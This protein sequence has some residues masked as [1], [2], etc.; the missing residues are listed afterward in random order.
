MQQTTS[1]ILFKH[2]IQKT[3]SCLQKQK[4]QGLLL[5]N[6]EN[7][8]YLT[9]LANTEGYL[10]LSSS[11]KPIWFTDFRYREFARNNPLVETVVSEKPIFETIINRIAQHR[12]RTIAFEKH[13]LTYYTYQLLQK[14]S[15]KKNL[16]LVPADDLILNLRQIKDSTELAKIIHAV[17]VTRS[18]FDFAQSLLCPGITE[19]TLTVEI[20]RLLM[21]AADLE[22]A[23]KP[24]IAYG[25]HSAFPHHNP[26]PKPLRKK[27]PILVDM[28][29]R[30]Q[31]Y[32]ADLTR[33]FFLSKMSNS[34]KRIADIVQ[35][36]RDLAIRS[37][38]PGKKICQID[39]AAREHIT[40]KGYGRFFGHST[41]HGVGIQ[42][43]EKPYV[44]SRNN[45][46]IKENMIFAIE[47][48]IYLPGKFGIR[49]ESMVRVTSTGCQILDEAKTNIQISQ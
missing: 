2:R 33:M 6:V 15:Q 36:A 19:Q 17:D 41:G 46:T 14:Q 8:F 13:H 38:K 20:I 47:P 24:I 32:C 7:I 5:A 25:C 9:G 21:A 49:Y 29:A 45:D 27:E 48:A 4:C 11:K 30:Y 34:C 44:N 39:Q 37:V 23:F 31:G 43:H 3:L 12:I 16:T 28:G 22:L 1:S 40:R 18:G 26:T 42:V 10:F 35:K